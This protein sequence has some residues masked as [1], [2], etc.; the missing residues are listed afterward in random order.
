[1]V[2]PVPAEIL[3]PDLLVLDL[4]YARTRLLRDAER[5]GC[6]T[7]DGGVMLLHQG[8][9]AFTLWTGQPAPLDVMEAALEDARAKGLTSAEGEPGAAEPG[10]AEPG[11]AEPGAPE[12]AG[13]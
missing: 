9:A 11:A 12:P 7:S 10:A 13:A 6:T 3:P 4:I 1:M 8:A 5:A 2:S